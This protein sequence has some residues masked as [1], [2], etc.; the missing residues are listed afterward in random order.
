MTESKKQKYTEYL[1]Q[2]KFNDAQ[3]ELICKVA[4]EF[5]DQRFTKEFHYDTWE[6]DLWYTMNRS[7]L[8]ERDE[9]NKT[10]IFDWSVAD[11]RYYISENKI[12][13]GY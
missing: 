5:N 6:R 12:V 2:H 3:I 10:N 7:G 13:I 8:F 9:D 4:D 1:K 11:T